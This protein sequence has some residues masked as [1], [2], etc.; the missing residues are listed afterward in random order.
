MSA[1][2]GA[3][4]GILCQLPLTK[5]ESKVESIIRATLNA[6]ES[7]SGGEQAL[8]RINSHDDRLHSIEREI[9]KRIDEQA[10]RFARVEERM[11]ENESVVNQLRESLRVALN[12]GKLAD[13]QGVE[14]TIYDGKRVRL[15]HLDKSQNTNHNASG[16][17]VAKH[18][19][20]HNYGSES[21]RIS[22]SEKP[23]VE[24]LDTPKTKGGAK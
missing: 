9:A 2:V 20:V 1:I 12:V 21:S 14:P 22:R 19:Q 18:A 24:K 13:E 6:Q 8:R 5:N 15:V 3:T 17:V 11:A 23:S 16:V 10:E 7:P 4:I